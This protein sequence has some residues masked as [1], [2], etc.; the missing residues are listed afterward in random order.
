MA[1]QLT[2]KT[3]Y[4]D[5]RKSIELRK[6]PDE[7]WN[8]LT[9]EPDSD[10]G[11]KDYFK[12]VPWLY[13]GA[14]MRADAVASMPFGIYKG[15][16]EIDDSQNYQNVVGF[17]PNP[18]RLLRLTELSLTLLGMGYYFREHNQVRTTFLKYL[19]ASTMQPIMDEVNGLIGFKRSL[20]RGQI[21][22]SVDEVVYFWLEDPYVE[23]GP[24]KTCPGKAALMASG[25]IANVDE[26]VAGYFKRGAIKAMILA[27]QGMHIKGDVEE[28]ESWWKRVV[29]GVKN[30]FGAKVL[31]ADAVKPTIIGEGLEAIENQKLTQEKRE[32]IAVAIGV[33]QTKLF[34]PAA[35]GLGGSGVVEQ[36][37]KDFL[38]NT[39]VPE[40]EFIQEV[41]NVQVFEP[42]GLRIRF[43]PETLDAFQ[44]DE[45]QRSGAYRNYVDGKMPPSIAAEI[46]G[47]ELPEGVEY[48]DLDVF[49]QERFQQTA[50]VY[51]EGIGA[52]EKEDAVR[53]NKAMDK[54]VK[55]ELGRWEKFALLRLGDDSA[56]PFECYNIPTAMRKEIV[57]GLNKATTEADVKAVFASANG[58]DADDYGPL[59]E[60]L[61][62]A[63]D[64][65]RAS[66]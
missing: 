19:A 23:L 61:A 33:P 60:G 35:S 1:N 53:A 21:D 51:G 28:L 8:W 44:T 55:A 10:A 37:D 46:L 63:V 34:S 14:N 42:M 36:D 58:R 64:A 16:D 24:P 59:L 3:Y 22:L 6:Y 40:C 4:F 26:F 54:S 43:K 18:R 65:L 7:A 30:A 32:D 57:A 49:Y 48:A 62:L 41:L 45:K 56:R 29:G 27:V 25:V 39:I 47:L 20:G 13:R 2:E 11:V 50:A 66:A 9:G 12:A 38:A 15:D 17:M 52:G 31:N 5:G